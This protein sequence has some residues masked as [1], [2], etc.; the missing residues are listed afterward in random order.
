MTDLQ[1]RRFFGEN[2]TYNRRRRTDKPLLLVR[3]QNVDSMIIC[4]L[5]IVLLTIKWVTL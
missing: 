1:E 5:P 4:L 2:T 3:L